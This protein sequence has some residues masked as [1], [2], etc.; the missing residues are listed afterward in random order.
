MLTALFGWLPCG[1]RGNSKKSS[2]LAAKRKARLQ[3][4]TLE[5]RAVP[6]GAWTPLAHA[7]PGSG[8][9]QMLMLLSD[10]TVMVQDSAHAG[11]GAAS[12]AWY[13]LTPDS[14]GSY[15]NGTWS[16]LASM[17]TA[18][19]FIASNVLPDGRVFILGGQYTGAG[20]NN[21]TNTGEI[22][23]P[24]ANT[25]TS[26]PNF[27]ESTYGS[28]PSE[29]LP[30]GQVLVVSS[31]G[32]QTYLYDPARNLWLATGSQLRYNYAFYDT[33]VKLPD[34]SILSYDTVS[35]IADNRFEAERYIPS[36][37]Q[38]VDA[39][40]LDPKNPPSPLSA[41]L[42]HDFLGPAF[43]LPNGNA[44]FFGA[45]GNTAIYDPATNTWTAG[46]AE[47]M[48]TI[49]GKQTQLVMADTALGA[50]MPNGD[51][52][53]SL[54]P[55]WTTAN[56]YP[57]P[58]WIYEFNPVT[59][60]YT[61]VT[62]AN[63]N[64]NVHSDETAMLVLPSGQVM[65]INYSKQIDV[66]TPDGAP[67][68]S[69]Q[70]AI[71]D[72]TNNGKSMFTLT[73]TQLNGLSEG[74][75]YEGSGGMASNYPILCLTDAN[76]NVSFARTFNWSSTGVATGS[77]PESVQ[78]TLPAT[79]V[80]GTY[81]VSVIAN[82]IASTPVLVLLSGDTF[83]FVQGASLSGNILGGGK[84]TLDYSSYFLG[85]VLV[86]LQTGFA[87]GVGGSVSGITTVYG[88]SSSGTGMYNLLIGN[89]GDT[90][91]G[92]LAGRNI[93]VAGPSAST[94][95][96]GDGQDILIGGSTAYDTEAGLTSWRR[97]AVSWAGSAPYATRV[98]KLTS[99]TG[100]PLLDAS[101]VMGNG[102]GN[103][104]LGDGELALLYTDGMDN[105]G[106]FDPNSQEVPITP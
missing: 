103:T 70:P 25:W 87:T 36:T 21:Y 74:A 19:L 12:S 84:D 60:T 52:L 90:L 31:N 53:L 9:A 64:L 24:V 94:L 96:G 41:A 46:P 22:Y 20:N 48:Q 49:N 38:W 7:F 44:I 71:S 77:T 13:Q 17:H 5:E 75:C 79:A 39:S 3:V 98:A 6:A 40:S 29:V 67:N 43:L 51:I 105:I 73:G 57:S 42:E 34:G 88:G 28:G 14:T 55:D 65:L 23:D 69:G 92:R 56:S 76:G 16:Q 58:S 32:P 33:W 11:E 4:E 104:F 85:A 63:F 106:L 93:L 45:N 101:M 68:A 27:P 80:P 97:I 102:G 72:I 82:G 8:V 35:S 86:D 59:N 15:M 2:G 26:I 95:I 50:M 66:F 81:L 91:V 89:G 62:P 61:D 18:R 83:Q 99:G 10:G 78:F 47:P 54:A 30:S 100:V 1:Q 37:G